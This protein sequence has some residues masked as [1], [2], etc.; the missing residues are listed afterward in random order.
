MD[1]TNVKEKNKIDHV[2]GMCKIIRSCQSNLMDKTDGAFLKNLIN[3]SGFA[4]NL[5]NNVANL[6][7]YIHKAK[8]VLERW[9]QALTMAL[10]AMDF[11]T[12]SVAAYQSAWKKGPC[13]SICISALTLQLRWFNQ[14][15]L[16]EI[17]T[18]TFLALIQQFL[19]ICTF[20]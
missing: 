11:A 8:E 20:I 18:I 14:V 4:K 7:Q 2:V 6:F 12:F 3:Q 15:G 19:Q 1:S 10:W 16:T 13:I 9:D 17:E 5:K